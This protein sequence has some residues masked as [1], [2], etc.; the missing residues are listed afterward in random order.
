MDEFKKT[1]FDMNFND[2]YY[3][4]YPEYIYVS[5]GNVW[6]NI[7]TDWTNIELSGQF[8]K[9]I[10]FNEIWSSI[11]STIG[12]V[13]ASGIN[14]TRR[15]IESGIIIA[16]SN[17]PNMSYLSENSYP[18]AHWN[19]G[20]YL[21]ACP[22]IYNYFDIQNLEF[23][24]GD[25]TYGKNKESG[26][27]CCTKTIGSGYYK[28]L[29]SIADIINNSGNINIINSGADFIHVDDIEDIRK[30]LE[31]ADG[32]FHIGI[33]YEY[34]PDRM[35][36][37]LS[38]IQ[39][40]CSSRGATSIGGAS[41]VTTCFCDLASDLSYIYNYFYRYDDTQVIHVENENPDNP[42]LNIDV[43][44][45]Y[46]IKYPF[47]FN[48]TNDGWNL[49]EKYFEFNFRN[50]IEYVIAG[51]TYYG[52]P[53]LT[54][55]RTGEKVRHCVH[56]RG[57][58]KINIDEKLYLLEYD[59]D[60]LEGSGIDKILNNAIKIN[61]WELSTIALSGENGFDDF[62]NST[63]K[64]K[65]FGWR[66]DITHNLAPSSI[67]PEKYVMSGYYN[68]GYCVFDSILLD[69][70]GMPI[71]TE[72]PD[73]PKYL[74]N[75]F[76]G[77]KAIKPSIGD[78]VI[79]LHSCF[80]KGIQF[81]FAEDPNDADTLSYTYVKYDDIGTVLVKLGKLKL[82]VLEKRN[83]DLK[84]LIGSKIIY[85][86]DRTQHHEAEFDSSWLNKWGVGFPFGNSFFYDPASKR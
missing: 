33:S 59:L 81:T 26:Y 53:V 75:Q 5:I 16:H 72:V 82:I 80:G 64:S 12:G 41:G 77:L 56:V 74:F 63:L 40:S 78:R 25:W 73:S 3:I 58:K 62:W 51:T 84:R 57:I 66:E 71:F 68:K 67:C 15:T 34:A 49:Y 47:I 7:T 38:D 85:F 31:A 14:T 19:N 6:N 32:N 50:T 23:L 37:M 10:D 35:I 83:G 4:Y 11:N 52:E 70:E 8:I 36:D 61:E 17:K 45:G 13:T 44:P 76:Y 54:W 20:L 48:V 69:I 46:L 42:V 1:Y 2:G 24:D 29:I 65:G 28:R 18:E 21:M 43:P 86:D 79:S 39:Y 60:N 30:C 9:E 55:N 22:Y 27:D